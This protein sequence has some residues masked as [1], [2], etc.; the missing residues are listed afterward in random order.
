MIT[1]D[2]WIGLGMLIFGVC[3]LWWSIKHPIKDDYST[4]NLKGIIAGIGFIIIGIILLFGIV[5]WQ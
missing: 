5:K 3:F 4:A 2:N 1:K